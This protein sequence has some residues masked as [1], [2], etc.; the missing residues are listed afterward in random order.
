MTGAHGLLYAFD[1]LYLMVNEVRQ[2]PLALTDTD[3]D[4]QFDKAELLVKI[5]GSGEHGPHSI[6]VG[7]TESRS[8][9][10]TAT[11]QNRSDDYAVLAASR[12]G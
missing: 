3:S 12:L 5:D 9:F 2:G 10:A 11:T 7:P 6:V 4:D 1:S 8:G